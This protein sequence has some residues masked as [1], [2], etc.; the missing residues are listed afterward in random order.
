MDRKIMQIQNDLLDTIHKYR[1]FGRLNYYAAFLLYAVSVLSSILA[2]AMALSGD[3]S[4]LCQAAVTAIPGGALLI[5]NTFRFSER[6]N[7]HYNKKNQL[8][9]LYRLAVTQAPGTSPPE[10][11][12]KWNKID[13]LMESS[14]PGFGALGAQ[15]SRSEKNS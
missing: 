4:G 9:A 14:W 13:N 2:T 8:N 5:A 15:P 3:F 7:W 10:I 11:A 6:S 1:K 12:E